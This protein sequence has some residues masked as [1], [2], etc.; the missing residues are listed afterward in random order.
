MVHILP[1][2]LD[3]PGRGE[4][5]GKKRKDRELDR[6][7]HSEHSTTRLNERSK[8]SPLVT[9]FCAL[10]VALSA[11]S[12]AMG[13]GNNANND[14]K[15]SANTARSVLDN[16]PQPGNRPSREIRLSAQQIRQQ[17]RQAMR[18]LRRERRQLQRLNRSQ[19]RQAARDERLAQLILSETLADE[20]QQFNSMPL[21]AN[22]ALSEAISWYAIAARRGVPGSQP[23]NRLVPAPVIRV[24]RPRR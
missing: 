24:V 17:R 8:P 7:K 14:T 3:K 16:L 15:T 11:N 21:V 4:T 9:M 13:M 18:E 10:I 2:Y 19:L 5:A 20:A 23:I 6:I 12:M 22:D 1:G